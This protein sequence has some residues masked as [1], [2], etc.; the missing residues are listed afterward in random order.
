MAEE[1]S[2]DTPIHLAAKQG[3]VVTLKRASKKDLH[4]ED[5]DGWVPL[6]W[7]AWKGNVDAIKTI[8]AKGQVN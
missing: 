3:D 2:V 8:L 7:A 1:E 5:R 4:R 6:H